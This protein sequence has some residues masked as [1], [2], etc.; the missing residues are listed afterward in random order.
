MFR[1]SVWFK[2]DKPP[3]ITSY[4]NFSAYSIE[5]V[6]RQ[7]YESQEQVD[8][9]EVEWQK[10]T[11]TRWSETISEKY[12]AWWRW[13]DMWSSYWGGEVLVV[14]QTN[15][16]A[17]LLAYVIKSRDELW[18]DWYTYRDA[19]YNWMTDEIWNAMQWWFNTTLTVS[20][21]SWTTTISDGSQRILINTSNHNMRYDAIYY[22]WTSNTTTE[23]TTLQTNWW[24]QD[25]TYAYQ[26]INQDWISLVE[27]IKAKCIANA[28][29]THDAVNGELTIA[30]GPWSVTIADKNLWATQVWNDGDTLSGANCWWYYQRWNNY[31]FPNMD[32][33]ETTITTS[34]TQVDASGYWPENYYSSDTFI[35][36]YY[37]DWANPQNDNLWWWVVW[38]EYARQ[39]PCPSGWHIP[40]EDERNTVINLFTTIRPSAHTWT[41]FSVALKLPFANYR[42][43]STA[44]MGVSRNGEYW[45]AS[46]FYPTASIRA[47]NLRMW[48]NMT[49]SN[50]CRAMGLPIRP[51]KNT[52]TLTPVNQIWSASWQDTTAAEAIM[53]QHP[54][55][56]YITIWSDSVALSNDPWTIYRVYA[57]YDT[58]TN[59]WSVMEVW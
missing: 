39:G 17:D 37:Q 24:L 29:I 31:M 36:E 22:D 14:F 51:F 26:W 25:W 49:V 27:S 16:N 55:D 13:Y 10:Q 28:T 52:Y 33:S 1:W 15:A 21:S 3:L 2:K 38:T 6:W 7:T 34:T 41:D 43:M 42:Y 56:Y 59:T 20:T 4:T 11:I 19:F 45:T 47:R 48:G 30:N 23:Y 44:K 12:L 53:N 46:T 35:K 57:S 9:M 8:V 40:N 54:Y 5:D 18:N 58:N 32:V 50:E